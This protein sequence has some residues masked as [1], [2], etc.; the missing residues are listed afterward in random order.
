MS[1]IPRVSVI[2]PCY[3]NG[4]ALTRALGSLLAQT[5]EDIE[6]IV[7]DDGSVHDPVHDVPVDPRIVVERFPVSR[8]HAT[9][10]NHGITLARAP[11]VTFVDADDVVE[12][13]Y[14]EQM[15]E[16]GTGAGADLVLTPILAVR[17]GQ[18][19]GP[20]RFPAQE[21]LSGP[22]ETFLQWARGTLAL[23]QHVL[24]RD[25]L[26]EAEPGF[27]FSDQVLP[28]RHLVR[29]RVV[30]SVR[31]PLYRATVPGPATPD[32]L[33]PT[34]WELTQM[35]R[36]LSGTVT[37]LFEP[38]QA[39]AVQQEVEAHVVTQMLH[40]A[41][42]EPRDTVLRREVYAWCRE[43]MSLGG[44]AMLL[45]HGQT[46]TAAS[47]GLALLS[48]HLHSV[49]YRIHDHRK[50]ERAARLRGRLTARPV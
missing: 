24:L 32:T 5:V 9:V 13:R 45:R 40:R 30:V 41:A 1:T 4:T 48:R 15:L 3:E 23:G 11:W 26:P 42:A 14:V 6:I 29:S 17:E 35:P 47:W 38:E 2:V 18:E 33:R 27:P 12:A 19:L 37:A 25:P 44:V 7:I 20:L 50:E 36:I 28:L 16:A 46:A 34:V 31:E 43:R 21:G 22:R 8:G 39:R 49:A 10:T